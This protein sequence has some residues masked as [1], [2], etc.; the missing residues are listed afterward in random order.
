M[1]PLKWTCAIRGVPLTVGNAASKAMGLLSRVA[2]FT[3]R[4]EARRPARP[5][6][7]PRPIQRTALKT[8]TRGNCGTGD[9]PGG[10]SKLSSTGGSGKEPI[11]LFLSRTL[12]P[13]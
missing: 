1:G 8:G 7:T 2:E 11:L 3:L 10:A 13:L 5:N 9:A 12:Q 4:H 6:A